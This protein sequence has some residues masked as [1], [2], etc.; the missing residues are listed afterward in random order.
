MKKN[1]LFV[2]LSTALFASINAQAGTTTELKVIG[3]IV[4]AACEPTIGGGGTVNYERISR[5]QLASDT[6]TALPVKTVQ[7]TLNCTDA[8]AKMAIKLSDNRLASVATGVIKAVDSSL[9]DTAAF[10]LGTAEGKNL[11]AYSVKLNN[12]KGDSVAPSYLYFKTPGATSWNYVNN[13]AGGTYF[14]KDIKT[15]GSSGYTPVAYK[16]VTGDLSV[17]AVI[18]KQSNLPAG[19]KVMLD[20]SSTLEIVYL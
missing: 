16:V 15:W 4:P 19:D 7:F 14:N 11:G 12:V 5:S 2:L 20:G 13:N 18:D 1:I 10:G 6:P 8:P 17:Q 3:E 9:T